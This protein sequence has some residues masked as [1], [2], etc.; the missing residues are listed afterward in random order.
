MNEK[1]K[2]T[3]ILVAICVIFLIFVAGYILGSYFGLIGATVMAYPNS[4]ELPT[5][6]FADIADEL[7]FDNYETA[8]DELHIKIFGV[9]NVT[10]SQ[11]IQWYDYRHLQDGWQRVVNESLIRV[12]INAFLYGWT[13]NAVGH[14]VIAVDGTF[15]EALTQYDTIILTSYAPIT[16]YQ[17]YFD[18]G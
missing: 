16:T 17:K 18:V 3:T 11:V 1:K 14:V 8:V 9:N 4:I 12:H 10:A 7:D 5:D 15:V 13:K 2:N 6:A